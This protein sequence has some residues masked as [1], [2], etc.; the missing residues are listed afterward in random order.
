[1][2]PFSHWDVRASSQLALLVL[3]VL[4]PVLPPPANAADTKKLF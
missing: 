2:L 4:L 3:L 1:V